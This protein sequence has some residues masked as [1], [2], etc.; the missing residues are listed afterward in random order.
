MKIKQLE[1]RADGPVAFS[2]RLLQ[3]AGVEHL[4]DACAQASQPRK[5][6]EFV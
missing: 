2:G 1:V 3:A 5:A 4:D 6:E